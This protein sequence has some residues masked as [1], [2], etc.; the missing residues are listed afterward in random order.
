MR[1]AP[2]QHAW[3]PLD[4]EGL[5]G[6]ADGHTGTL[7]T[8]A[9][10][11]LPGTTST[12]NLPKPCFG[13]CS[14]PNCKTV[15]FLLLE[16]MSTNMLSQGTLRQPGQGGQGPQELKLVE[17]WRA[18]LCA[19]GTR[20]QGTDTQTQPY[21]ADEWRHTTSLSQRTWI[22]SIAKSCENYPEE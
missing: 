8:E 4:G 13:I 20:I 7:E 17:A 6:K 19:E 21:R 18:D 14:L 3:C 12:S 5:G 22:S 1:W 10:L 2:V 9:R 16:S 15:H 11:R